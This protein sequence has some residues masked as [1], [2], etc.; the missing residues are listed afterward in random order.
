[1]AVSRIR[2]ARHDDHDAVAEITRETWTERDGDYL[3]DVY[4]DWIDGEDRHTLVAEVENDGRS[5]VA[6]IA[7]CVLLTDHEAW[8]QGLRVHPDHRGEGISRDLTHALFDWAATEGATTMRVM[9]FSWNVAGLGQARGTGYDPVTEFRWATP[10]PD[11][12][13]TPDLRI[14]HD[15]DVAWRAWVDSD[16]ARHLRGVALDL[17]ESWAV[18]ELTR[19]DLH[20]A[21]D[22]TAVMAVVRDG[23]GSTEGGACGMAVRVREYERE[24]AN[25]AER[26]AEYGVGSWNDLDAA[27]SLFDAI[28]RDAASIGA[29]STRVLIPETV[30]HVSDVA[31]TRTPVSDEPDFV[32]AK[33]L[34]SW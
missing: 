11:S 3:A 33:D 32:L 2:E 29:D 8:G 31:A 14:S 34:T 25:G 9:V 18:S 15:P 13:A 20:R 30:R 24:G 7:Q 16:A 6:G 23:A 19:E 22:E 12:E 26:R 21:A 1:M 27:R 4:P 28:R 10:E 17:D 5:R